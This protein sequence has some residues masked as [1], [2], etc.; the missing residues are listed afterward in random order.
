VM[1][2]ECIKVVVCILVV[3]HCHSFSVLPTFR[4]LH[5]EIVLQ[6]HETAKLIVP[7]AT[8][9]FQNNLLFTALTNLDAATF[10]VAYQLKIATTALFSNY[11]LGKAIN[12]TK[13]VSLILLAIGVALAQTSQSFSGNASTKHP[14]TL[15]GI[16]AVLLACVSSGF[17]GVYFEKLIKHTSTTDDVNQSHPVTANQPRHLALWVRNIQLGLFSMMMGIGGMLVKDRSHIMTHGFFHGYTVA[18]WMVIM[19][20]AF[21]GLLVAVVVKYADNILK[22]FSTS[23]SIL[24]SSLFSVYFFDFRINVQFCLGTAVV[25]YAVYLYAASRAPLYLQWIIHVV[26]RRFCA[27]QPYP[28]VAGKKMSVMEAN[29]LTDKVGAVFV[30]GIEAA[31]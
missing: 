11:M 24:L 19:T 16:T 7:A 6:Y 17:S 31:A 4:F 29:M 25:L 1:L 15:V 23:V 18:T 10:Q 30:D 22:G 28:V 20:G 26:E 2:T 9:T 5:K 21:G 14:N 8:Y 13:W 27:D 3:F 12:S